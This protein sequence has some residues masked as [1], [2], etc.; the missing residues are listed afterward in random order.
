MGVF[1]PDPCLLPLGVL[2]C[3]HSCHHSQL[4]GLPCS[5]Q[6]MPFH[7]TPEAPTPVKKTNSS[8]RSES[9]QVHWE[10]RSWAQYQSCVSCHRG[11]FLEAP[12]GS[13]S[14]REPWQWPRAGL[15]LPVTSPALQ[16]LSAH[17]GS[18]Q[19]T[20]ALL[21][22][23]QQGCYLGFSLRPCPQPSL[24]HEK[25]KEP[26]SVSSGFCQLPALHTQVPGKPGNTV[27]G[28]LSAALKRIP[29]FNLHLWKHLP[30]IQATEAVERDPVP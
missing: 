3:A 5:P 17:S 11:T 22:L 12:E 1:T 20:L 23:P 7:T 25:K 29:L 8:R 28:L 24:L 10:P 14:P 16:S 30:L 21:Q 2:V 15:A 18:L 19:A 13:C 6:A 4:G 26:L 27:T 9:P